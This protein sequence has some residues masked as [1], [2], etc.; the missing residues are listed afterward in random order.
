MWAAVM[1]LPKLALDTEILQ[2]TKVGDDVY[3]LTVQGGA[4]VN[5]A[6]PGQFIH[7]QIPAENVSV[8]ATTT[9]RMGFE[10]RGEGISAQAVALLYQR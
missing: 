9:E 6:Q 10:G 1:T 5:Q 8:K 2:N 7:L 3:A 4:L